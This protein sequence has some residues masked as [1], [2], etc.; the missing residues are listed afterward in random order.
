MFK[1][2]GAAFSEG[3]LRMLPTADGGVNARKV[4]HGSARIRV[5]RGER[6]VDGETKRVRRERRGPDAARDPAVAG[7]LVERARRAH[8]NTRAEIGEKGPGPSPLAQR[9]VVTPA[10]D[11]PHAAVWSNL[12]P[13][14]EAPVSVGVIQEGP[15]TYLVLWDDSGAQNDDHDDLGVRI[16]FEPERERNVD[17]SV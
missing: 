16:V 4:I 13:P 7:V 17:G 10:A 9:H 3:M 8:A 2:G 14:P 1:P 6:A 5:R 12:A 15:N 11:D